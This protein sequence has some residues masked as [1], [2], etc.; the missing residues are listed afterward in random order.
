MESKPT[1]IS[2]YSLL[3]IRH[4]GK[5]FGEPTVDTAL[6]HLFSEYEKLKVENELLKTKL[7]ECEKKNKQP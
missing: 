5:E 1:R 3:K 6:R 7:A 2:E 4:F